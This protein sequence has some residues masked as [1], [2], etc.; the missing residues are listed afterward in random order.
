MRNERVK[1]GVLGQAETNGIFTSLPVWT[2]PKQVLDDSQ[3]SVRAGQ[4]VL[5][6]QLV[7]EHLLQQDNTFTSEK[8]KQTLRSSGRGAEIRPP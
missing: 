7:G 4:H 2:I 6:Q 1:D 8:N 5:Q 3:G